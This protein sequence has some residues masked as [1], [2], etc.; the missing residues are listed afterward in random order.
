MDLR[1]DY[2]IGTMQKTKLVAWVKVCQD[3]IRRLENESKKQ[4]TRLLHFSDG[5]IERERRHSQEIRQAMKEARA[6]PPFQM[7]IRGAAEVIVEN[8]GQPT[9]MNPHVNPMGWEDLQGR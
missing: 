5:E 8:L 9:K 3:E 6:Q 2:V 7:R 4:A 1:S